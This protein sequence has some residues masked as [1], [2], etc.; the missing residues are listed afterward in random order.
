MVQKIS[1]IE[2][3]NDHLHIFSRYELP[4]LGGILLATLMKEKGFQTEAIFMKTRDVLRLAIQPDLVAISTITPTAQSA[5]AIGDAMRTKG[6]PVVYGGPHVTFFPEEALEHGD[7]CIVGEGEVAMPSLVEALNGGR[8]FSEVPGLVWRENGVIRR[9]PTAPPLENL[10]LLP[11][12]DFSLLRMGF[13]KKM[14]SINFGHSIIPMQTS[15]GC[16]FDCSFCSVTEMF[17]RHYRH[18]ST[19]SIIE[20]LSR[21]DPKHNFIFFYDDNFAANAGRTK[22]LLRAMIERKL[23]FQWS[24]QVRADVARDPELL[25]LMV[26]AGCGT[27]YI[28]F[29]SVDPQS[30][31]EMKKNQTVDEIRQAIA[32]IRKRKIHIHGMFILGFDSDSPEKAR[33]TVKFAIKE[34]IDSVQ[35]MILTPLPGTETYFKLRDEGRIIDQAWDTY[36]AHHVKFRPLHFSP[37]ELQWAQIEAHSRFYSPR[38]VVL[39]LFRGRPLG[40]V[41]GVYAN[42]LNKRWQRQEKKYLRW[43]RHASENLRAAISHRTPSAV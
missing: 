38:Q 18:R 2:P 41:I 8:P 13:R 14:G 29:E 10:D 24:T 31:K 21:Y 3:K 6:I 19:E 16:P 9:T 39:R 20:E 7:Y 42:A 5:Y 34:K 37:W 33:A 28:G 35:F 26:R 32:L 1:F 22:E 11:F 4:R 17:G 27:L 36:D 30:L 40:F 25:D 12:P 23:G 15:R 43:L